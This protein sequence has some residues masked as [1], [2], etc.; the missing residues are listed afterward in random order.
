MLKKTFFYYLIFRLFFPHFISAQSLITQ[1]AIHDRI[2]F[3]AS[4]Q[5]KGRFPGTPESWECAKFIRTNFK[6]AGLQP[7][8]KHY[9]QYFQPTVKLDTGTNNTFRFEGFNGKLIRDY[10]PLS[11]SAN[12]ASLSG[13]VIFCGYGLQFNLDSLTFDNYNGAN[14]SEKW[15]MILRGLPEHFS[16]NPALKDSATDYAKA[17]IAIRNG[18]AGILFVSN[19]DLASKKTESSP[20][21]DDLQRLRPRKTVT[22]DV[23]VLQI[24]RTAADLL[25]QPQNKTTQQLDSLNDQQPFELSPTVSATVDIQ[26]CKVK[27][28]NVIGFIEGSDAALKDEYIVLGAHYDHLGMGGFFTGSLQPDT[29]AIHNG[30]DDNASG[31]AAIMTVAAQL[32]KDHQLLK[33]SVIIVAFSAEEEG[34]LGSEYF[35]EHP[36]VPLEKIKVMINLDMVGHLDQQRELYIGGCGTFSQGIPLLDSLKKESEL[37]VYV[38]AGGV[39]GSDHVSFYRKNIPVLGMHTGGHREYHTP[40][41]DLETL[42]IRVKK[43]YVIS[44]MKPSKTLQI[45]LVKLSL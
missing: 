25:L 44:F 31:S 3:F 1:Q 6:T 17:R 39:G 14:I 7:L 4:D 2:A 27:T 13:K 22:L 28:A 45:F 40:K 15:V 21:Y 42:N 32:A 43:K 5:M 37:K 35:T 11:F 8:G 18:A 23:P 38:I 10:I 29:F 41:D 16:K 24:K 33:R 36:P 9:F 26:P 30:A 20:N 19:D 12:K 34:L